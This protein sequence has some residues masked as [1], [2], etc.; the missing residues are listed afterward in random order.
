MH[1]LSCCNRSRFAHG[2]PKT[3]DM[4]AKG[5]SADLRDHKSMSIDA[6]HSWNMREN[7]DKRL[8]DL[9]KKRAQRGIGAI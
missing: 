1:I 7:I 2:T 3:Q 5:V 6:T 8:K 9:N 4:N